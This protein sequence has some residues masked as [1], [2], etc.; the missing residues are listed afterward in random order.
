ME[1][2]KKQ[3]RFILKNGYEFIVKCS[4]FSLEKNGFGDITS[5]SIEGIVEN[6]PLYLDISQV[7][8]IVRI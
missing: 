8:A 1:E 2:E 5:Y 3:I 6:K 7:A 4:K